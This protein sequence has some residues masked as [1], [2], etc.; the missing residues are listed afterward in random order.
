MKNKTK[1][2][3][4]EIKSAAAVTTP[5]TMRET[6]NRRAKEAE[7]KKSETKK[8]AAEKPALTGEMEKVLKVIIKFPGLRASEIKKKLKWA[9]V[10]S[11]AL[12]RLCDDGFAGMKDFVYTA[13]PMGVKSLNK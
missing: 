7:A 6:I 1:A 3:Q 9:F 5:E 2:N 13:E 10:P 4:T 11:R 8:P 12:T